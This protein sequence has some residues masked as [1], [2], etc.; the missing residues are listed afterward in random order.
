[1]ISVSEIELEAIVEEYDNAKKNSCC[2]SQRDHSR[3]KR[4]SEWYLPVFPYIPYA[5]PK[6]PDASSK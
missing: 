5:I 1:M 2:R 6:E 3:S 4:G